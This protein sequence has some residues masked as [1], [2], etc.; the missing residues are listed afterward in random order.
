MNNEAWLQG[1]RAKQAEK[2]ETL[3]Q[4]LLTAGVE[5]VHW[6]Q[7]WCNDESH[8]EDVET[9]GAALPSDIVDIDCFYNFSPDDGSWQ[10]DLHSDVVTASPKFA[11]YSYCKGYDEDAYN[12]EGEMEDQWLDGSYEDS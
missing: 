1:I 12:D 3:R 8:V 11:Q 7:Q 5:V 6:L 10:W 9:E 2:R 4:K